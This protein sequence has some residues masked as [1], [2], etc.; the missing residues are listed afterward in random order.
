MP[1]R[2]HALLLAALLAAAALV[3]APAAGAEPRP[4]S[5]GPYAE[6]SAGATGFI[7]AG[8]QYSRPGPAFALRAGLDLFSWLSLGGRLELETHK[9]NVPPPPV[10]EYVQLYAAAA[11]ARVTVP[12]G[13]LALFADGGLGLAMMSSNVL[14]KVDVLEPGERFSPVVSAGGGL[15]LQLQNRHYAAG[16]AGHWSLLPGFDAMQAVGGRLY[17]RYTYS[18][19]HPA[20][21]RY[22]V[23]IEE[24]LSDASSSG[25][26]SSTRFL[27]VRLARYSAR[28][29]SRISA[30]APSARHSG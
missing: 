24:R 4:A 30:S 20:A 9:A 12:L 13:R 8:S 2:P 28:S 27:P 5:V 11:D 6:A 15:E 23:R 14:A 25:Q 29:A 7:G 16:L 18:R 26:Y 10:G 3:D 19:L 17:L 22:T 21:R 1:P